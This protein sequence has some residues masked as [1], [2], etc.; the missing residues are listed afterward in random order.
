MLS[1]EEI[2]FDYKLLRIFG[3]DCPARDVRRV[4]AR[5]RGHCLVTSETHTRDTWGVGSQMERNG[6]AV[7]RSVPSGTGVRARAACSACR[8]ACS[9]S[10]GAK[11]FGGVRSGVRL[12]R[13][14]AQDGSAPFWGLSFLG[15]SEFCIEAISFIFSVW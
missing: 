1:R 7:P 4:S 15:W 13:P 3:P 14:V 10:H 6:T 12:V 8:V 2:A 9:V 5:A 11:R